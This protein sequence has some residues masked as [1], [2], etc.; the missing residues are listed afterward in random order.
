M[1]LFKSFR[2][3]TICSAIPVSYT[4]LYQITQ[5]TGIPWI[6]IFIIESFHIRRL[7]QMCIRDSPETVGGIGGYAPDNRTC[8]HSCSL[9]HRLA[10]AVYHQLHADAAR[11][12][13][14]HLY[15]DRPGKQPGCKACLLYTS[16]HK[17]SNINPSQLYINVQKKVPPSS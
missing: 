3:V 9:H 16:L 7:R 10:G 5:V 2:S 4:H 17:N 12:G 6:I 14:G 1:R 11:T 8:Q 13:A 15:P